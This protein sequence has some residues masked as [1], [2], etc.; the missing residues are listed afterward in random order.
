MCSRHLN[1]EERGGD[2][3][4]MSERSEDDEQDKSP[5]V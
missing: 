1:P 3:M 2:R 5:V 4:I